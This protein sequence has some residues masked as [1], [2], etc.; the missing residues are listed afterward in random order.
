MEVM[1]TEAFIRFG[2]ISL[3]QSAGHCVLRW[4]LFVDI[5]RPLVYQCGSS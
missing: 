2:A 5:C 3:T 4:Q 1:I